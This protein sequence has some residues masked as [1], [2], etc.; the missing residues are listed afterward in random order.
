[1]ST[2]NHRRGPGLLSPI[3]TVPENSLLLGHSAFLSAT[4]AAKAGQ[5]H[6]G[7][8]FLP[9]VTLHPRHQTFF[10]TRRCHYTVEQRDTERAGCHPTPQPSFGGDL[11]ALAREEWLRGWRRQVTGEE[12]GG[13]RGRP[14]AALGAL[15]RAGPHQRPLAF[16]KAGKHDLRSGNL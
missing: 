4:V 6:Y 13:P 12:G 14:L 1:M 16:K 5:G 2:Q 10:G 15:R 9:A 11:R 8:P 3:S 7:F